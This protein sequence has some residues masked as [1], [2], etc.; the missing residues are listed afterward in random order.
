M[1]TTKSNRKVIFKY[2]FNISYLVKFL[3]KLKEILIL[4]NLTS[5]INTITQVYAANLELIV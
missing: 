1:L 2:L 3:K 5:K 4:I